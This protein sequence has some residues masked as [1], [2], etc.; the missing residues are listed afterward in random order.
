MLCCVQ[1]SLRVLCLF[2]CVP[3]FS[4]SCSVFFE[5][6]GI[7]VS[8][9]YILFFFWIHLG[10]ALLPFIDFFFQFYLRNGIV[11]IMIMKMHW[12]CVCL[13]EYHFQWKMADSLIGK[14][15]LIFTFGMHKNRHAHYMKML[16]PIADF[17][18]RIFVEF[19]LSLFLS[20]KFVLFFL[21]QTLWQ[22]D[23]IENVFF[24]FFDFF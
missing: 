17:S 9:F 4:L 11:S 1:F 2:I 18:F 3:L 20:L 6:F 23:G 8:L 15:N 5:F 7:L 12:T 14:I 13:C 19:S 16:Q 21:H 10:W 24:W 22:I